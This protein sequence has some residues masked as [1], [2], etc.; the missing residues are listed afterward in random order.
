M[1]VVMSWVDLLVRAFLIPALVSAAILWPSPRRKWVD[2]IAEALALA[3]GFFAG[4]FTAGHREGWAPLVPTSD[5]D[6]WSWLPWL[7]ALAGLAGL[8][9]L[10]PLKRDW[11]RRGMTAL[12]VLLVAAL[13]AWLL[14]PEFETL[15][16][17]RPYYVG[18]GAAAVLLLWA[19]LDPLAGRQPGGRIPLL[20]ACVAVAAAMVILLAASMKLATLAGPLAGALTGCTVVGF[21][22]PDRDDLRGMLPG[23]AVLLVGLLLQ[24]YLTR[25]AEEVPGVSF[26]LVLVAP[27]LL[28]V[29]GR[30]RWGGWLQAAAVLLPLA[31][32]VTLALLASEGGGEEDWSA[33]SRVAADLQVCRE[34]RQTWRSAATD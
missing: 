4:Y 31:A 20:L 14:V 9:A 26:L 10:L 19:V 2:R 32:A 5:K 28:W 15:R 34:N 21:R 1:S 25:G 18:G 12:A 23:F 6:E 29:G 27:L 7:A 3:V 30:G 13:S 11:A 8:A 17:L 16:A 22:Y 33:I 24:G